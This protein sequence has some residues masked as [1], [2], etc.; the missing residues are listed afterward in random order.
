MARGLFRRY[1]EYPG[2]RSIIYLGRPANFTSKSK[3]T[4]GMRLKGAIHHVGLTFTKLYITTTRTF[5]PILPFSKAGTPQKSLLGYRQL[6]KG[7]EIL[8][9]RPLPTDSLCQRNMP[10]MNGQFWTQYSIPTCGNLYTKWYFKCTR[11]D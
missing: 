11:G 8:C 10:Q 4:S 1:I 6:H 5:V 2:Y 9:F 7:A 3:I